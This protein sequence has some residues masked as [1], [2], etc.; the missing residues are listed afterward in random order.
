MSTAMVHCY[1]V[2][3]SFEQLIGL[4]FPLWHAHSVCAI[5]IVISQLSLSRWRSW[6]RRK[7]F[8]LRPR[9]REW[10]KYS[11][12]TMR[13]EHDGGTHTYTHT[14]TSALLQTF[15]AFVDLS[16]DRDKLESKLKDKTGL[17]ALQHNW[18][19]CSQFTHM[20]REWNGKERVTS[21]CKTCTRSIPVW[22]S[23]P[24]KTTTAFTCYTVKN[25]LL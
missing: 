20:C 23:S 3:S 16:L 10:R 15:R 22:T 21:C 19:F 25:E 24:G 7:R 1:N 9:G 11:M 4:F 8:W 14:L 17:V 6:R 5:S 2:F 12:T 13:L 18:L